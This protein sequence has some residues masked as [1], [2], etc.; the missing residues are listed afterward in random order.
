LNMVY[1]TINENEII[2][3]LNFGQSF[4]QVSVAMHSI[5]SSISNAE[6]EQ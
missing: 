1:G 6:L 3:F 5:L 4:Y 2:H